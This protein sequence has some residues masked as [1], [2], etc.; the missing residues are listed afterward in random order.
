M[1]ILRHLSFITVEIGLLIGV[2][3]FGAIAHATS[4]LKIARDGNQPY[5]WLDFLINFVIAT[6]SGMLFGV[7]SNEL[8]S[9]FNWTLFFTATGAF[10]GLVGLNKLA[11]VALDLLVAIISKRK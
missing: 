10:L 3:V 6:F 1:A 4:Q 11:Q 8:L 5:G 7:V 9:S 2:G